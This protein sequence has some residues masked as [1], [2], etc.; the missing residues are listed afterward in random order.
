[1]ILDSSYSKF[2]SSGSTF[3][4]EFIDANS[5]VSLH[6]ITFSAP[7]KS[8]LPPVVLIPG[9]ASVIENFKEMLIALTEKHI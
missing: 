6:V 2:C 4:R 5:G 3:S 9:M 1:M 8:S 7:V